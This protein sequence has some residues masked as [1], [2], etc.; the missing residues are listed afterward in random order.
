MAIYHFSG[1]VIARSKGKSAIA[2]AAYRAGEKLYDERQE[3]I[4]DYGRKQD[5]AYKEIMLPEGAPE[6]MA[7]REKLWNAVERAENR[8]DSQLARE[9]HFSLPREFTKEQNIELAKEFVKN[10]FVAHGMIAD[11]CIHDCKTKEGEEQPHAHVMLTM[12]EVTGDGF[13]LKNRSWNAKEN[14]MLWREAWAEHVN[15]YLALNG[16]DQRLDHRSYAEQG[17]DLTPQNKVGPKNLLDHEQRIEEHRLIAKENGDKI[18]E[19]PSIALKAIT[20]HQST[21][22]YQDLARFINRHTIDAEQFQLVY[23]KVKASEQMVA[24]KDEQGRERFTT[25]EMMVLESKMVADAISLKDRAN[26]AAER[27]DDK[28]I[29]ATLAP[30]LTLQQQ[31]ALNHIIGDGDIKC[32]VGYAGTGKS[33]LL[34]QA[35]EIW[36]KEGYRVHGATLSGIAA[37]NLEGASGIKS[38]TLASR[39]YYWDKGEERLTKKDVLVIDEAGMLGSRQIARVLEEIGSGGAKVVFIGDPQQLQAIEAGAAFRAISEQVGYLELTEI[40]RQQEPWQQEATKEFAVRHTQEAIGLYEQHD[41]LHLFETKE[42]AK[43]ALVEKWDEVRTSEPDKSQIMLAYT[44]RDAQ[45]LNELARSYRQENNE[46]GEGRELQTVNGNKEFAVNDR[47]Y[48]LRNDRG[49]GVKN[50]T[51]GTIE[52]IKGIGSFGGEAD[53]E[54]REE[55]VSRAGKEANEEAVVEKETD[56]RQYQITVRLDKDDLDGNPRT[57]TFNLEQ[58]GHITHGYAATIHKAQGVTVDQ[59]Y[60]LASKHLDSHAA[61]VGMSRHRER[62]DLYWSREE[63]ANK[64]ELEQVL[65]RDRSKDVTLDYYHSK[66]IEGQEITI[67]NMQSI[68]GLDTE[69]IS[70][71]AEENILLGKSYYDER[72]SEDRVQQYVREIK[73]LAQEAEQD[74]EEQKLRQEIESLKEQGHERGGDY[75]EEI[76]KKLD[77]IYED[78]HEHKNDSEEVQAEKSSR[79][80]LNAFQEKFE[81]EHPDLVIEAQE[82]VATSISLQKFR[83]EYIAERHRADRAHEKSLEEANRQPDAQLAELAAFQKKFEQEHPKDAA[84]ER[85]EIGLHEMSPQEKWAEE[86]TDRYYDFEERYHDLQENSSSRFDLI[87]AKG[88]MERCAHEICNSEHAMEYLHE[89]DRELFDEMNTLKEQEKVIELQLQRERDFE[90]SL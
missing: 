29:G 37:E 53:R 22:T 64:K 17:I 2:S 20:H 69:K 5:I 80:D 3:K 71:L 45:E 15:K 61:Y 4:F 6:W 42:A 41:C 78:T 10:E 83:E 12:R 18:L 88:Q 44:R 1:T 81:R 49:M 62:A 19:D 23:E 36:E 24:L 27:A 56:S 74:P 46:L 32:L 39:C 7:N 73:E 63:F 14:Y 82:E 35:K 28:E 76:Y 89:N 70:E 68:Q 59:S 38:R 57:V 8:K 34:G 65:G 66:E 67:G 16:I 79:G 72:S 31:D 54:K 90:M 52:C 60:I 84:R 75:E 58:Y 21:F 87:E 85:E 77:A 30:T 11:L 86:L 9:V 50:G 43:V 13:G 51:L 25:K 48:F 40:R 26:I 55:E 47:I 33:H